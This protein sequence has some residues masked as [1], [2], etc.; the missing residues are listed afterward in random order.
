MPEKTKA[1][2]TQVSPASSY[3]HAKAWPHL[4]EDHFNYRR[5]IPGR[6]S[7]PQL[8]H[9]EDF[10]ELRGA[11][12]DLHGLRVAV[13]ARQR[14]L[15]AQAE[16]TQH[17]QRLAAVHPRCPRRVPLAHGRVAPERLRLGIG[18]PG[19]AIGV[20]ARPLP[21]HRMVSQ[22]PLNGLKLP[23]ALAEL[24]PGARV[25]HRLVQGAPRQPDRGSGHDYLGH[26]HPPE[27]LLDRAIGRLQE[28]LGRHGLPLELDIVYAGGA[29]AQPWPVA[30]NLHP[31]RLAQVD[32]HKRQ[33]GVGAVLA[34][35]SISLL[36]GLAD[37]HDRQ[38][39]HPGIDDPDLL[40]GQDQFVPGP[41]CLC[42]CRLEI[43][44]G[45]LF[46]HREAADCLAA[47]KK[48]EIS[49]FLS[50]ACVPPDELDYGRMPGYGQ[51]QP[52][53]E[54]RESL[55]QKSHLQ[56]RSALAPML[57]RNGHAQITGLAEA[58]QH[59]FDRERMRLKRPGLRRHL[60]AREGAIALQRR[61]LHRAQK[62]VHDLS[63]RLT[64]PIL[65]P[66]TGP[67]FFPLFSGSPCAA[68]SC[69]S[70][71]QAAEMTLLVISSSLSNLPIQKR[72]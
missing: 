40:A 17:L 32:D 7:Y 61:L 29:Q 30:G 41:G 66:M 4:P 42:S 33:L 16:R 10:L 45:R 2:A 52:R 72:S 5:L 23:D 1:R 13:E 14:R 39:A 36:S 21:F 51:S 50:L 34:C 62:R 19:G 46:G 24:L 55:D 64:G 54:L 35:S 58:L 31:A 25:R 59:L 53:L 60:L 11:L 37:K 43:R 48:R 47:R 38:A 63:S 69:E 56:K 18:G 71:R 68:A 70:L 28:I 15:L 49:R 20:Q 22:L 27:H 44:A 26:V 8:V 57:L 67:C 65:S 3:P 12:A 9:Q 6:G